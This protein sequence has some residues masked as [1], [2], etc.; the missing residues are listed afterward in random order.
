MAAANSIAV[1]SFL[2]KSVRVRETVFGVPTEQR[3]VV[4]GVVHGL[5]GSVV[6]DAVLLELPDMTSSDWHH[7]DEV[8]IELLP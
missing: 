7:L 3:G 5:P 6:S 2:G 8:T 4:V 1:T